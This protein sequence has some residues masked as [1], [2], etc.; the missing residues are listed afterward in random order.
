ME[1]LTEISEEMRLK[2]YFPEA[3]HISRPSYHFSISKTAFYTSRPIHFCI[4]SKSI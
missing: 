4:E 3:G 1:R 2:D